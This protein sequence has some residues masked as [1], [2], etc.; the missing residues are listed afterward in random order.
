M[1][2][3]SFKVAG[4]SPEKNVENGT[5]E[6]SQ[7][8]SPMLCSRVVRFK[9]AVSGIKPCERIKKPTKA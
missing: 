9:S 6:L 5:A 1:N 4:I 2:S 3:E 8:L 7:T